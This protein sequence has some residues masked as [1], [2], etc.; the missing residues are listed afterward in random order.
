MLACTLNTKPVTLS[1][2]GLMVRSRAGLRARR[3][4]E[5]ADPVQQLTYAEVADR[6][7][8]KYRR[9]VSTPVRLQI[10]IGAQASRHRHFF[11]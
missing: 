5:F 6:T 9:H 8:E 7:A 10:E 11:A 2:V 3:G 4:G 1:S